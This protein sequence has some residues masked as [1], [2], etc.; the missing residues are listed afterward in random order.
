[1]NILAIG[2]HFDDVELGC[3][4]TLAKHKTKGDRV[5]TLVI[6]H[7]KY[8]N[9]DGTI[10]R[11]KDVALQEGKK[12]ANIVGYELICCNHET[13][14]VSFDYKLIENINKVIDENKI[15]IIYT[16]WD[17]DVHQDHQAIGKASLAAG[18]KVNG[19]LMYQ[20]NLYM[21]TELFH[22]NYFVD[23]SDFIDIKKKSILA[24]KTEI[25]KFGKHWI[26]FW[27]NE[28]VNNGKK[29]NV[30]Y[31]EAFQLVKFLA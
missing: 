31:A 23:I 21:N 27:V 28:A 5:I 16:H 11:E 29:F 1:M 2:A 24:H 30:K 10:I 7:S 6:T 25:E 22:G 15:D 4:G 26:D 18:R 20:S 8:H 13:K 17:R 19:L 9:H 3:S 12:A 14:Q